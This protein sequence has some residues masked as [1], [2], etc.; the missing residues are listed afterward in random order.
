MHGIRQNRAP[1]PGGAAAS[2]A[3]LNSAPPSPSNASSASNA[4]SSASPPVGASPNRSENAGDRGDVLRCV[5]GGGGGGG[6]LPMTAAG[7][8]A[9]AWCGGAVLSSEASASWS[10]TAG[11]GE[12]TV[13]GAGGGV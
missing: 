9:A 5:G 8:S 1:Y 4:A 6:R 2:R 3:A 13:P 11:E 12:A 10:A 7:G